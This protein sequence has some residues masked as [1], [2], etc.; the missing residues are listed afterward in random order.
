[1]RYIFRNNIQ[2]VESKMQNKFISWQEYQNIRNSA[3]FFQENAITV[4]AP[5]LYNALPKYLWD[6]E[7]VKTEKFK[8]YL[9]K[10][11][12][13]ILNETKMPNYVTT[14]RSNSILDQ[15]P[16]RRAQGIYNS[17]GV[18]DSATE[19]RLNCFTTTPIKYSEWA[20]I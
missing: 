10:F 9:D 5:R 8:F 20:S 14:S 11:F 12:D 4:L 7:S 6:I 15:L 3:L 13:L 2:A 16:H 17:G 18:P 1:M 19:Q